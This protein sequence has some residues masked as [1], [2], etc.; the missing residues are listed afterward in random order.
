MMLVFVFAPDKQ[1]YGLHYLL[2]YGTHD[3]LA[4]G[5]YPEQLL[6]PYED[7]LFLTHIDA[8]VCPR[9]RRLNFQACHLAC[10]HDSLL[11]I[12]YLLY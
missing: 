6:F 11:G 10:M 7:D 3:L 4:L 5:R 12:F 9:K 8:H 2:T 1:I